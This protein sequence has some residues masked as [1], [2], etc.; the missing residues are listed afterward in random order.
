MTGPI[1]HCRD[2]SSFLSSCTLKATTYQI[3]IGTKLY[4]RFIRLEAGLTIKAA[5][6]LKWATA[7]DS[8]V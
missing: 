4:A 6:R 2:P 5:A 3:S 1:S 8:S 7:G